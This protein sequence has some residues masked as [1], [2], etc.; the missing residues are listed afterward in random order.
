[1]DQPN[2]PPSNIETPPVVEE[3]NVSNP[4]KSIPIF[5]I[6]GSLVLFVGTAAVLFYNYQY[7]S[8]ASSKLDQ[9]PMQDA[10]KRPTYVPV[11]KQTVTPTPASSEEAAVE[12]IVID[13]STSDFSSIDQAASGL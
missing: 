2:Q 9:Y 3:Q 12:N 8:K 10:Y 7:T 13:E 4:N 5:I 1:M 6:L 11:K